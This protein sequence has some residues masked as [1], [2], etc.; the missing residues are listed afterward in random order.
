MDLDRTTYLP[1]FLHEQAFYIFLLIKKN[2]E[3]LWGFQHTFF[4]ISKEVTDTY[5]IFVL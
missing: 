2:I 5:L 1:S 4:S 3:L